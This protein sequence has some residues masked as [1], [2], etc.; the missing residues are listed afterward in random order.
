MITNIFRI[1]GV[2]TSI[3]DIIVY[4]EAR[5]APED[6]ESIVLSKDL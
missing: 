1:F 2:E 3:L 4:N 5:N 6:N